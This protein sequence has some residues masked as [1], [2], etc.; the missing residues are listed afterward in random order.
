M[1]EFIQSRFKCVS[2][3]SRNNPVRQTIPYIDHSHRK[4]V[5][6]LSRIKIS[7]DPDVQLPMF[8]AANLA[9]LPPVNA[10]HVDIS[11]ILIELSALRT[12]Y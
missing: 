3:V 11:A 2:G 8:C 9:R 1:P 7:L 12:C 6:S 10:S 4:T 5:F